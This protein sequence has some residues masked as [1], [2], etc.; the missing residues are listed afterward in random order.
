MIG[1]PAAVHEFATGAKRHLAAAQR[2]VAFWSKAD[3]KP[4]SQR[5]IYDGM[6][7]MTPSNNTSNHQRTRSI[8]RENIIDE[9]NTRS[10]RPGRSFDTADEVI[11]WLVLFHIDQ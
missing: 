9:C 1:L 10:L 3:F 6:Q 2:S 5:S 8:N 4:R 11:M 7:A